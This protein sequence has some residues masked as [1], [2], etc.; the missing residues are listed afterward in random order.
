MIIGTIII[1]SC[2]DILYKECCTNSPTEIKGPVFVPNAYTPNGDQ[3]NDIFRIIERRFEDSTHAGLKYVYEFKAVQEEKDLVSM[4]TLISI[5]T[6]T[7][8]TW[9]FVA[10]DGSTVSGIFTVTFKVMDEDLNVY[11]N[12]YEICSII[13]SDNHDIE[14]TKCRFEDQIDPTKGFSRPTSEPFCQ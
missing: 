4:D 14:F 3:L 2:G 8:N 7:V 1:S 12:D 9:D 11:E 13:C 5:P 6:G 10:V